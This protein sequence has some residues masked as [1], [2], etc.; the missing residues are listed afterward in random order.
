MPS[1]FGK[2]RHCEVNINADV[3]GQNSQEHMGLHLFT[4]VNKVSTSQ[5]SGNYFSNYSNK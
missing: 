4:Q 5:I 3:G 1:S 2:G